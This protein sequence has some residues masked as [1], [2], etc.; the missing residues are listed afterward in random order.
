M[1]PPGTTDVLTN[2]A[3]LTAAGNDVTLRLVDERGAP[4]PTFSAGGRSYVMAYTQGGLLQ[5]F[6][7]PSQESAA[8][9]YDSRGHLL[10]D[11]DLN[12][13][14]NPKG[15]CVITKASAFTGQGVDETFKV[16]TGLLLKHI[17]K[18]HNI[19]I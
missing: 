9:T 16:V 6:T 19:K 12:A 2:V 11:E 3:T 1:V 15:K 7:A 17:S 13:D 10:T 5:R 4:L 18:K 14:L 8:M